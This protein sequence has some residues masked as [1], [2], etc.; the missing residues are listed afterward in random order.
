MPKLINLAHN[1]GGENDGIIY[2]LF[3][4]ILLGYLFIYY[5]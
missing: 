3:T 5:I 4:K 1:S 2:G